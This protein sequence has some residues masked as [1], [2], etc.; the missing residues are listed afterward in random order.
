MPGD[1]TD[2][3]RPTR[4]QWL[5]A[6]TLAVLS[7]AATAAAALTVMWWVVVVDDWRRWAALVVAAHIGRDEP[8]GVSDAAARG[9][10]V[11]SNVQVGESR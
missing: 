5:R 6:A 11:T 10:R 4:A 3:P 2:A 9:E 7:L 8:N 1:A